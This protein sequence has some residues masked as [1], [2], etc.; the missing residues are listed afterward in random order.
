MTDLVRAQSIEAVAVAVRSL[1]DAVDDQWRAHSYDEALFPRIACD[2]LARSELIKTTTSDELL[3]WI[4]STPDLP[5]QKNRAFGEPPLNLYMGRRF[6]IECLVWLQGQTSIHEHAFSGAFAVLCGQSI[7]TRYTFEA[8]KELD[9]TFTLGRANVVESEWLTPGVARRI[10]KGGALLHSLYHIDS[11]TLTIVVRTLGDATPQH[12]LLFPDALI[13]RKTSEPEESLVLLMQ[14]LATSRN[15][16][17]Q[18]HFNQMVRRLS[19]YSILRLVLA[20]IQI[21]GLLERLVDHVETD[22]ARILQML[23]PIAKRQRRIRNTV[24]LMQ[25]LS[26]DAR[27]F[28][29]LVLNVPS[30]DHLLEILK[31]KYPQRDPSEVAAHLTQ[32][33]AL[34][35]GA[36]PLSDDLAPFVFSM[37]TGLG[38]PDVVSSDIVA[39]WRALQE[40]FCL[41]ALA[42]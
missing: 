20:A 22:A 11:P 27:F 31:L 21:P 13:L 36:G 33:L 3:A 4:L 23:I 12:D 18:A 19:V 5:R 32:E 25:A 15:P 7:H 28:A 39:F 8:L 6:F 2:V 34:N 1:A 9:V 14:S 26:G 35:A 30:R 17:F 40:R 16:L 29:A 42:T 38:Q 24:K 41:D 37:L 10:V